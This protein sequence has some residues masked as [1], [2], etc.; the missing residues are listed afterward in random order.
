[1]PVQFL[2]AVLKASSFLTSMQ[3][4]ELFE[5]KG[6]P[7]RGKGVMLGQAKERIRRQIRID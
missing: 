1:M 3:T 4:K 6:T 5:E 2:Q 7:E